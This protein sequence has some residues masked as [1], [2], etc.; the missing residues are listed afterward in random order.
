MKLKTEAER[1]ILEEINS[2]FIVNLHY[3]FQS[4]E[5]LYFVLDFLNGG[6]LFYHL[7]RNR[8]FSEERARFYAAEI[9][10]AIECLHKNEIV[11]R[12]LKPENVILD[13]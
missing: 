2:P 6:E 8:M 13:A 9:L 11:Y 12:D 5:R 3:A 1:K 4:E 7:R 10:L